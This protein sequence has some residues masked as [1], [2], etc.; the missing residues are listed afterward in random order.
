VTEQ[1]T[2]STVVPPARARRQRNPLKKPSHWSRNITIGVISIFVALAA[3]GS[4]ISREKAFTGSTAPSSAVASQGQ[5]SGVV[6]SD[7]PS[8]T[9]GG[10]SLLSIKGTGPTT[11]DPF[12][13]TGLSVDV[14]YTF[15]C[16]ADDSFTVN[17][18]G[19]NGSPL[20]PDVIASDFGATGSETV[21]EPLNGETGPFTV[22]VDSPC[23]WTI[24]VNGT[25]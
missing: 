23:A 3:V 18:Y 5:N 25:P 20:L 4:A 10:T 14:A 2:P 16:T 6:E 8:P 11:S 15:T 21:N 12:Q 22:E 13:S 9:A 24:E 17:F 1:G 19:T 7:A